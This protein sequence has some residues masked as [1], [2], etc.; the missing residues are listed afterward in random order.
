VLGDEIKRRRRRSVSKEERL[1]VLVAVG[2][3]ST[4]NITIIGVI[5]VIR[6][7]SRDAQEMYM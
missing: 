1:S 7:I 3:I 2:V 5:S 6:S 4:I